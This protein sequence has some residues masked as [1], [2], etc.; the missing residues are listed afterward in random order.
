M[1]QIAASQVLKVAAI[2]P[3]TILLKIIANKLVKIMES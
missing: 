1:T 3:V 2:L